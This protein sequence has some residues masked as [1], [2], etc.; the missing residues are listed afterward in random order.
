MFTGSQAD[1]LAIRELLDL[2][3]DAVITRDGARWASTWAEDAVWRFHGRETRGRDAIVAAWATAMAGYE[4][5]FFSAFPGEIVATGDEA[6]MRTHTLEHL[7]LADG[8]TR[9]Q[10]GLYDDRLARLD[11]GW[12]F[13]ERTFA[14]RELKL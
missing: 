2:Y 12:K 6:S 5:V 10:S 11:G 1:R 14:S 3:S 4:A 8:S 13:T 9:L 7:V